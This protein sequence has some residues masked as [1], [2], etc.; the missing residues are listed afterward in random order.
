M[1]RVEVA[2]PVTC[3]LPAGVFRRSGIHASPASASALLLRSDAPPPSHNSD[4]QGGSWST[5]EIGKL[6]LCV[7]VPLVPWIVAV[8][9]PSDAVLAASNL[10]P[11]LAAGEVPDWTVRDE[12]VRDVT[13]DISPS[14]S[15]CT[16]PEKPF[17]DTTLMLLRSK[18]HEP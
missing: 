2:T 15:K 7:T 13:P 5:T 1:I 14:M 11:V 18:K 4:Q 3:W 10:K 16:V 8:K 6:T 17:S 12:A 9:V